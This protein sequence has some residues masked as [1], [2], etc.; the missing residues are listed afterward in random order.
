MGKKRAPFGQPGNVVSYDHKIV[1][2]D[3]FHG[4]I[5]SN[6]FREIKSKQRRTWGS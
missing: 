2:M 3:S 5:S 1:M 4:H 6:I